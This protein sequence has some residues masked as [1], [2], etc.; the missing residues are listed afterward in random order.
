LIHPGITVGRR[1]R[2]GKGVR[3]FLD[4]GATLILGEGCEVDD[5]ATIAI[6]GV[7]RIELGPGSFVGHR[8][9]LAAHRSIVLGPGAFLAELVSVRDHDHLVG[10]SP[11]SGM[12]EIEPVTIGTDVWIGSKTTVVRGARI[13]DRTVVGANA[14]VRG[15][16]PPETVC[17]GIPA[18]VIRRIEREVP[19]QSD[20]ADPDAS[21]AVLDRT[22]RMPHG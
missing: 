9:T 2:F 19:D 11:S 10:A 1:V 6:Y 15:L 16:L 20:D 12:F 14:L 17:G 4:R 22:R 7:G 18:R 3:L 21:A 13:G 5:G 8:G